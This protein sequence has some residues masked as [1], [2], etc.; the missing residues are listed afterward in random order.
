[1]LEMCSRL[2]DQHGDLSCL[3]GSC[4]WAGGGGARANQVDRRLLRRGGLRGDPENQREPRHCSATD[5]AER[6]LRV[7]PLRGGGR[8]SLGTDRLGTALD[9]PP[10]VRVADSRL[11]LAGD[12]LR[13][14]T[15]AGTE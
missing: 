12:R 4:G 6:R 3:E 8:T 11:R 10:R 14:A 9:R 13:A 5:C 7:G 2:K 1:T 15:A